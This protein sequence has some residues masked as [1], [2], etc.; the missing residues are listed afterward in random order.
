MHED[1]PP[2]RVGERGHDQAPGP[3]PSPPLEPELSEAGAKAF[4]GSTRERRDEIDAERAEERAEGITQERRGSP[5]AP[6]DR[7]ESTPPHPMDVN[8]ID[9]RRAPRGMPERRGVE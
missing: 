9:Q 4:V 8:E 5:A 1:R 6:S 3:R 7:P 2:E